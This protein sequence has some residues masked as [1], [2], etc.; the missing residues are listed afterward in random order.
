[1]LSPPQPRGRGGALGPGACAAVLVWVP[2]GVS[3]APRPPA[4]L[5]PMFAAPG[6]LHASNQTR[7]PAA[8]LPH[9]QAW[10]ER[11]WH[12]YVQAQVP[13]LLP[14]YLGREPRPVEARAQSDQA[15]L[16]THGVIGHSRVA[17]HTPPPP[18]QWLSKWQG[19]FLFSKALLGGQFLNAAFLGVTEKPNR[20]GQMPWVQGPQRR[21]RGARGA[22]KGPEHTAQCLPEEEV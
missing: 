16:C 19:D 7:P 9:S 22:Q 11:L 3:G 6:H 21:P 14:T 18:K 1:M 8:R 4:L 10:V 17:P 2:W 5:Y 15:H 20:E 13:S 12:S